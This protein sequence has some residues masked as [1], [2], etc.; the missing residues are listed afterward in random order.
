MTSGSF[1]H[2]QLLPMKQERIFLSSMLVVVLGACLVCN[3]VYADIRYEIIA[4]DDPAGVPVHRITVQS[5]TF[6]VKKIYRSMEGPS[7]T[8]PIILWN[9][10]NPE[11]LWLRSIRT[12]LSQP[13]R[14]T[15]GAEPLPSRTAQFMCHVNVD[16][17]DSMSHTRLFGSNRYTNPRVVTLSQ[18]QMDMELPDGFGVPLVSNEPLA[19]NMQVLNLNH[20]QANFQVQHNVEIEFV[21]DADLQASGAEIKPLFSGAAYGLALIE[22]DNGYFGVV[23]PEASQHGQSCLV[24]EG[25][26]NGGRSFDDGMGRQFTGH[27]VVPPGRQTN[28]TNVTQ[29]LQLPF[30]TEMH[31]AAVHLHPFAESLTFKNLTTGEILFKSHAENTPGRIG[32]DRVEYFSSAEGVKLYRDHEYQLISEYNNPTNQGHDSMAVMYMYFRDKQFQRPDLR[33]KI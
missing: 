31:Y 10:P 17:Q 33:S 19:V 9:S 7:E 5:Q 16:F 3:Q 15:H 11:L 27:W 30:D 6:D 8:Q 24:G 28:H 4:A 29:L 13:D 20:K 22:G 21:R 2:N 26:P 12:T 23:D 14:L 25:A 1:N 18:G 32:L